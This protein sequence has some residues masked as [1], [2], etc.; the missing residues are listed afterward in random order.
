MKYEYVDLDEVHN[1]NELNLLHVTVKSM[2]LVV[3]IRQYMGTS[4]Q[5]A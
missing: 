1:V 2:A 5:A 3:N 4:T